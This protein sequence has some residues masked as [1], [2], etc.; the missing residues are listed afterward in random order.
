MRHIGKKANLKHYQEKMG[1]VFIAFPMLLFFIFMALPAISAIYFSFTNYDI[2]SRSEWVGL[3]NYKKLIQDE[4]FFLTLK[5]ILYYIAMAVPLMVICSLGLALLLNKKI[6]GITLFRAI[7]YAPVITSA[8]A[9]STIWLWLLN[10]IYGLVNQVLDY[11]RI[12][13][14]TWLTNSS[15]AMVSI[16]IVVLWQNVGVSIIIYLAGLQGIPSDLYEVA[17]V[18]GANAFQCFR[19][20]TLPLLKF[21][22]FFVSTMAMIGAFQ[23]FDQAYALTQ[24]G[25]CNSTLTPVYLIYNNGFGNLKMGYASVQA[26]ALFAIIFAFSLINTRVYRENIMK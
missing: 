19:Y 22:T 23:L 26:F 7:Y 10:P 14:P 9:A 11:F 25:P 15:T 8:I 3:Y 2:I 18:D 1:F 17:R 6:K 21:A 20:V 16:V 13:G 5:N 4:M 24:G 12:P